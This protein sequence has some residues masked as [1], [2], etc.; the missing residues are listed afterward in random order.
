MTKNYVGVLGAG[1]VLDFDAVT[2]AGGTTAEGLYVIHHSAATLSSDNSKLRV[3]LVDGTEKTFTVS[4]AG[5]LGRTYGSNSLV[6]QKVHGRPSQDP[7]TSDTSIAAGAIIT[8]YKVS[9]G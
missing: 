5:W 9:G 3:T 6:V 4:G 8:A 2:E 7:L 1:M